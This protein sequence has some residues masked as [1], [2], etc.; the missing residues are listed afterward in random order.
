MTLT[1]SSFHQTVEV[2]VIL[3]VVLKCKGRSNI[4]GGCIECQACRKL[5]QVG[6]WHRQKCREGVRKVV[7]RRL[8]LCAPR[9]KTFSERP[10][11]D[12]DPKY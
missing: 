8:C 12:S 10:L 4:K 1:N 7:G 11:L 9:A 2:L 6:G 5:G 3:I